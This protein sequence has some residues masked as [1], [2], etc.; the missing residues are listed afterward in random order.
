MLFKRFLHC[1]SWNTFPYISVSKEFIFLNFCDWKHFHDIDVPFDQFF[2]FG[3]LNV[4]S[5]PFLFLTVL[6]LFPSS[7]FLTSCSLLVIEL[8]FLGVQS[9]LLTVCV[10][11][12]L[13]PSVDF[14]GRLFL[15]T[16]SLF[17]VQVQTHIL[18]ISVFPA[19]G[20]MPGTVGIH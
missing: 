12:L 5:F 20:I 7:F 15:V 11:I 8:W 6:L 2:T 13:N 10:V 1:T 14:L 9:Y 3:H 19:C 16:V 18:C 17:F 4:F